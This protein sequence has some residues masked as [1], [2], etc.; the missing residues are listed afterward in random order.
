MRKKAA[1][2]FLTDQQRDELIAF[3]RDWLPENAKRGYRDI[4]LA[5]PHS[6]WLHPHFA[7]DIILHS[8]L[9]G[10]G[11]TEKTLGVKSLE[12]LWPEL[13]ELAVLGRKI[14]M[15]DRSHA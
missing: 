2:E 14:G 9:R 13:L 10:N 7:S 1:R 11:F 3:L 12:P 5:F 15:R 8:A 4:M 6:W